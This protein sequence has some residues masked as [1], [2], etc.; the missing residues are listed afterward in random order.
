MKIKV[1]NTNNLIFVGFAKEW[2]E[3]NDF[4]L[5]VARMIKECFDL[6]IA[7]EIW[8]SGVWRIEKIQ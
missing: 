8:F 7:E 4:D 6:G 1:F 3:N 5:D 2:L